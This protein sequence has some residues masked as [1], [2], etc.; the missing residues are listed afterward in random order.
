MSL[1]ASGAVFGL[2]AVVCG[3]SQLARPRLAQ[4]VEVAVLG[5]FAFGQSSRRRRWRLAVGSRARTT[6]PTSRARPRRVARHRGSGLMSRMEANEKAPE[7]ILATATS[8]GTYCG[9]HCENH[10][11]KKTFLAVRR[12][13]PRRPATWA[14]AMA[15]DAAA[16][17]TSQLYTFK[18]NANTDDGSYHNPRVFLTSNRLRKAAGS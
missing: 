17:N 18:E 4:V 10:L 12:L 2:F 9:M 14:L 7:T 16:K 15:M 8:H 13:C 1:G 6:W 11:I 3:A 5:Q